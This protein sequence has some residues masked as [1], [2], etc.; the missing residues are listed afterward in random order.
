[1]TSGP[2]W[3]NIQ[4]KALAT[5]VRGGTAL[6]TPVADEEGVVAGTACIRAAPAYDRPGSPR[7]VSGE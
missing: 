6:T 5:D 7:E 3:V 2:G 1:M 4:A